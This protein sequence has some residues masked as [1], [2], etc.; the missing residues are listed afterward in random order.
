MLP[1]TRD[2]LPVET[3]VMDFFRS[4]VPVYVDD[5][6]SLLAGHQ[7]EADQWAAPLGTLSAGE[8][9]RLLLAVM[10]NRPERV[11]LL[12][13]P[14]NFLDFDALEVL[15]EALRRYRGTLLVVTHDRYF[16]EAAGLTRQWHVEDG[17][18]RED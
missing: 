5:A 15:E 9:R 12:D 7:F 17:K 6:E 13:E 2:G 4:Q 14:T 16:A 1:Q 3:T 10:V 11:L 8:L 18:V